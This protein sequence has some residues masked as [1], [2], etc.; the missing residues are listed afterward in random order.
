M[1]PCSSKRPAPVVV[2]SKS[3][4][5]LAHERNVERSLG[6]KSQ[7]VG[8]GFRQPKPSRPVIGGYPGCLPVCYA[9]GPFLTSHRAYHDAL[10]SAVSRRRLPGVIV[11]HCD[12]GHSADTA[13]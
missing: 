7:Q 11:L 8:F 10:T 2:T 9:F 3:T 5:F 13:E 4:A 1:S 12:Y 6:K